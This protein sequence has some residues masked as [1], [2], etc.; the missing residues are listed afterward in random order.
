MTEPSKLSATDARALIGARK[1]SP[2][3]LLDC[4]IRRIERLNPI[5]NALPIECFDRAREEAKDAENAVMR[6]QELGP[7][8]G[9]PLGVKDLNDLAGVRTTQ[10]SPL[11][12]NFIPEGDDNIVAAMRR[13]GAIAVGKTNVPEHG[14]GA[15]TD[16]PLFGPTGNPYDPRL[17]AGASSGGS[18]AAL[19]SGMLPLAMGSDF[20]GSLRTPAA[21]CGIFGM[22][23]SAGAVASSRRTFGW[24]PFDV[25][26]PLGRS[27][28]D[29]KMLLSSMMSDSPDPLAYASSQSIHAPARRLDLSK[30]R[31]AVS[32]DLGFAPMSAVMRHAFRKKLGRIEPVFASIE[33]AHPEMSEADR[34]FYVLRGIGFVHDFRQIYDQD[35]GALG[36]TITDELE[37]AE[38]LT[39]AD[40]GWA[41]AAQTRIY[42]CAERFFQ[43]FDLLITPAASVP[44]FPHEEVYPGS[45]DGVDMGGYLRWEA[46]SYGVTLFAGPAVVIPCGLGPGEM[47]MGIQLISKARSDCVLLD[48]AHSLECIFENDSE[49]TV[50]EPG[51]RA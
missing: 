48:V 14:F 11:F 20:A 31:V 25:E 18:A 29:A 40:I 42:H 19:G 12:E 2:V 39:I 51:L 13:A 34:A 43:K 37:R 45:I 33:D 17:S 27:A 26:G 24:S 7:L 28:A 10:G 50:P 32:E 5:L 30:L 46:I 47:P 22:R 4:C 41:H 44:P 21:Y 8:H 36:P 23:P 49:L 15:N 6:G 38:K 35:P 1:L 16:N 3:E 9:L